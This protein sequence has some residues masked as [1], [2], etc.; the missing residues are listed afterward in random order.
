MSEVPNIS[1]LASDGC[2]TNYVGVSQSSVN[3]CTYCT[4]CVNLYQ[5]TSKWNLN[6]IFFVWGVCVCV[7]VCVCVG[8][9]GGRPPVMW[10]G[11]ENALKDQINLKSA[12]SLP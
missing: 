12:L 6:F 3:A 1:I 2:I 10:K 4:M 5:P 9:G 11:L 8:G 7:C